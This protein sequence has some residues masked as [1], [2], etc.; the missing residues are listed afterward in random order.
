M[1]YHPT[2]IAV[3][4][5]DGSGKT[6]AVKRSA[7]Q[8]CGE[9]R[10][11][12]ISGSSI[13]VVEQSGEKS[14]YGSGRLQYLGAKKQ[15]AEESGNSKAKAVLHMLELCL[16]YRICINKIQRV[17]QPHV[18]LSDRDAVLDPAAFAREYAPGPIKVQTSSSLLK[19]T[20]AMLGP[21]SDIA[22]KLEI[23]PENALGRLSRREKRA[24]AH[25]TPEAL[26]Q[27]DQRFESTLS[28]AQQMFPHLNV[29]RLNVA[30]LDEQQTA[31][32]IA[33]AARRYRAG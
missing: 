22:I 5:I 8:L 17:P 30:T 12:T 24:D 29:I 15:Q 25:E 6:T 11:L 9:F 10:V 20:N 16:I 26:A 21:I 2:R 28:A 18:I 27:L 32:Q 1:D 13:S 3:L 23:S 19:L 31:L 7:Q 4:G 33:N 14:L